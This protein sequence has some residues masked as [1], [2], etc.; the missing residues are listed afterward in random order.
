VPP[1]DPLDAAE[2]IGH[3]EGGVVDGGALDGALDGG[4]PGGGG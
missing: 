3:A 4:P 1:G 2:G